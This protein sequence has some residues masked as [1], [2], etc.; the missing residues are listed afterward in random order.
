MIES[1]MYA[2]KRAPCGANS[3]PGAGPTGSVGVAHITAGWAPG[4]VALR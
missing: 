4:G 1:M 2:T 3:I